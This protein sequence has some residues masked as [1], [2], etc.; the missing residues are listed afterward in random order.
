MQFSQFQKST[1]FK[2]RKF[3]T[4]S[5]TQTYQFLDIVHLQEQM[6]KQIYFVIDCIVELR[7]LDKGA[8]IGENELQHQSSFI[9]EERLLF[10]SEYFQNHIIPQIIDTIPK[11]C[12]IQQFNQKDSSKYKIALVEEFNQKRAVSRKYTFQNQQYQTTKRKSQKSTRI[13]ND[14]HQNASNII[15]SRNSFIVNRQI[16]SCK[17]LKKLKKVKVI[18]ISNLDIKQ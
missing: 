7:K 1:L 14:D 10:D 6:A 8:L 13:L 12:V 11:F 18:I 2:V 9:S 17:L 3:Y 5:V 16:N 15:E 4:N